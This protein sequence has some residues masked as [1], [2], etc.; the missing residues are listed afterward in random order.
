MKYTRCFSVSLE[1][2]MVRQVTYKPYLLNFPDQQDTRTEQYLALNFLNSVEGQIYQKNVAF[3][4]LYTENRCLQMIIGLW[5]DEGGVDLIFGVQRESGKEIE[6][7]H[8]AHIPAQALKVIMWEQEQYIRFMMNGNYNG[9]G[10]LE[11]RFT[12]EL[13]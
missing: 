4:I 7:T 13:V 11:H 12:G 3:C 2:I 10:Y 6:R 5:R 9:P 1:P 8:F